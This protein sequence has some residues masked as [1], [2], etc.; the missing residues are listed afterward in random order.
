MNQ[1]TVVDQTGAAIVI[2]DDKAQKVEAQKEGLLATIEA[3]H[4]ADTTKKQYS[5]AITNYYK[6]TGEL[7]QKDT[8]TT[9]AQ[10]LNKSSRAFLKA[11]VG[12]FAKA[13][14]NEFKGGAT[15]NNVLTV[16]AAVYRLEALQ[17]AIEVE[18]SKGM[19]AHTWL[20][21]KQVKDLIG[22]AETLRDRVA[23]GLL[24][25]AG[26]RRE[27]AVQL[28]F[29][30]VVTLPHGEGG[31]VVLNVLG[32][33]AKD[34][35]V[36]IST[37]LAADIAK[38]GAELGNEGNVLRSHHHGRVGDSLSAVALFHIARNAGE[39]IGIAE[40]AP[41]DLRRTYAQ[42]GH[43]SGISIVQISIL[44]GHSSVAVTMRYLKLDV[45]LS[46]TISDFIP[47]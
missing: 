45:D 5:K 26:L 16:Q 34:R 11:A 18:S 10:T 38:L 24:V 23:L 20:S 29:A 15:P 41:H 42:I 37:A 31:R 13:A 40:L 9:Y 32:K 17:E 14:M 33:G 39:Q 1:L 44:L 12:R 8:L 36:P 3:S 21:A 6:S 30:D 35:I 4:L 7:L 27:E 25:G 46:A 2:A 43:E 28:T 22:T 47:Y 19:K